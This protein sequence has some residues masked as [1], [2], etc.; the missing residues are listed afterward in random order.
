VNLE[1]LVRAALAEE[2]TAEPEETGAYERFLR[3]RRRHAV[4]AASTGLAVALVLALAVGTALVAGG[5]TGKVAGPVTPPTTTPKAAGTSPPP[6]PLQQPAP[7]ATRPA[8]APVPVSP[9][10]VV[11]RER[12]G[13]ELTLPTG[14]KVD[15]STTR[16]YYQFGQ[17]W[18]VISPGGRPISATEQRR[19]TIHTA[20]TL[21]SEYPGKPVKGR[22]NLGA[23][24]SPPCRGTG[25]RDAGPTAAPMPSE[26]RAGSSPT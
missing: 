25:P 3:Q 10:G 8:P 12:Q 24:R 21:P 6:A 17:P 9:A 2:A 19:I 13:F 15:Q 11:R 1:E 5:G 7:Q 16:G 22:D 14:W 23:S 4:A 20:V 26:T 18:L